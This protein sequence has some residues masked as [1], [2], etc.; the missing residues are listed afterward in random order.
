MTSKKSV[1]QGFITKE[2]VT[3][4][5]NYFLILKWLYTPMPK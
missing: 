5:T 4:H 3:T 1:E 2:R